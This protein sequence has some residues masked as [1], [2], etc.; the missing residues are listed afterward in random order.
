MK[1]ASFGRFFL[2]EKNV[3]VLLLFWVIVLGFAYSALSLTRHSHFDSG[4]F[5]LGIYDQGVW[6]YSRFEIPYSSVKERLLL[7]DHLTL[8]L[9]L[10]A[11]LFYIFDDV[12]ALLIFQAF[13]LSLS[14]IGVYKLALNRKIQ[15]LPSFVIAFVYSFFYGIQFAVFF[16]FHPVI[17]AAGL[18]PWV[19]YALEKRKFRLFLSLTVLVILTQENMG[20]AVAS[21]G[22]VYFFK[23]QYRKISV[24]MI[25]TGIIAS[26][27]SLKIVSYFSN[28]GYEYVPS[29]NPNPIAIAWSFFDNADK[30]SV[31]IYSLGLFSFLPLLSPGSILGATLDLAQYFATGEA[32]SRM[33]SPFMH[34]R[35]ILASILALGIID[36]FEFLRK[37]GVNLYFLSIIVLSL[38]LIQQYY[39]HFPLNK[40]SKPI[41]HANQAWMEDNRKIISLVPKDV[42]IAAQ[43]NLVPHL[44]HRKEIYLLYP[45]KSTD[46]KKCFELKECWWLDFGGKPEYLIV[47]THEGSTLT[48]LLETRENFISALSNMQKT[49]KI[50]LFKRIGDAMV[51]RIVY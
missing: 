32:F 19:A 42:P 28:V 27:V 40:L 21:I 35:I 22:L 7:G 2:R 1:I 31:W 13:W 41:F 8:T 44:S 12:R 3:F 51:Y 39:F 47:D 24:V 26:F 45:K 16:D 18:L 30:L 36:A 20:L 43:Q 38:S 5:D 11:P 49:G 6:L 14:T 48:Q 33:W 46:P 25:L 15:P 23:K 17:I 34:H 29:I 10:I 50:Q 4:A 37:K 9:P